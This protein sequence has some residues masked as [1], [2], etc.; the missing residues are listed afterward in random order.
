MRGTTKMGVVI[1]AIAI[2][3]AIN[4]LS[5][6]NVNSGWWDTNYKSCRDFVL[7]ESYGTER[8]MMPIIFNATGLV[9]KQANSDDFRLIDSACSE[10]GGNTVEYEILQNGTDWVYFAA[11]VNLAASTT[12]KYSFYWNYSDAVSADVHTLFHYANNGTNND[13]LVSLN[14]W[15]DIQ[16]DSLQVVA[17]TTNDGVA[18]NLSENGVDVI[19][20]GPLYFT[21]KVNATLNT[22]GQLFNGI[23]D[24]Y[25]GGGDF[26]T[27]NLYQLY[28]DLP[29]AQ[30][31]YSDGDAIQALDIYANLV[32]YTIQGNTSA[33]E[34][35]DN[36]I[37]TRAKI[38]EVEFADDIG[39]YGTATVGRYIKFVIGGSTGRALYRDIFL[40]NTSFNAYN[41]S[42]EMEQGE[43]VPYNPYLTEDNYIENMLETQNYDYNIRIEGD[44]E[45]ESVSGRF[46]WNGT[47]YQGTATQVDANN[48]TINYT[49]EMPIINTNSSNF[50]FFWEYNITTT[51]NSTLYLTQR[52]NATGIQAFLLNSGNLTLSDYVV[53]EGDSITSYGNITRL[54]NTSTVA[55]DMTFIDEGGNS[56]AGL[57]FDSA[58]NSY[59]KYKSFTVPMVEGSE[60]IVASTVNLTVNISH[61]GY[62]RLLTSSIGLN[63]S[64]ITL[65]ENSTDAL[66][67]ES[68]EFHIYDEQTKAIISNGNITTFEI[69]FKDVRVSGSDITREFSFSN[70]SYAKYIFNIFPNSSSFVI[71]ADISY[72]ATGY[73]TRNY[74]I[75]NMAIN[76]VSQI[77]KLYLG[78]IS[79]TEVTFT[80]QDSTLTPLEGVYLQ[81]Q[82]KDVGTGKYLNISRTP[83]DSNG[84]TIVGIQ[85]GSTHVYRFIVYGSDGTTILTEKSDTTLSFAQTTYTITIG[86]GDVFSEV[87]VERT[88]YW[89]NLSSTFT[90]NVTDHSQLVDNLVFRTDKRVRFDFEQVCYNSTTK[91][92]GE[93][94]NC[95]ITDTST[96]YRY[97]LYADVSG[98]R[99][100][101]ESG[102]IDFDIEIMP[103]FGTIGLIMVILLIMFAA[104][105]SVWSPAASIIST[106]VVIAGASILGII[107]ISEVALV[108]LIFVAG[109]IVVR[110][111][112]RE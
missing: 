90:C 48:W 78:N 9:D 105:M 68:L 46:N 82:K 49:M 4:V 54:I 2:V 92:D 94:Y 104:F 34:T 65:V 72:G 20:E 100:L 24:H 60:T 95:V 98:N 75:S 36:H 22:G 5:S 83:T 111:G 10:S 70:S 87:D 88:C 59:T 25:A 97:F 47:Y 69:W 26:T 107:G 32:W 96:D 102:W 53:V 73:D 42:I 86:A 27:N 11:F 99:Y 108:S 112:V 13:S 30:W 52:R 64:K 40:S 106:V 109:V 85:T 84:Q 28:G 77:I 67:M 16:N 58:N 74:Y 7:T 17:P 63:I 6:W 66:G 39:N 51:S 93:S 12:T 15:S 19:T 18:F 35:I 14:G 1:F 101:L 79:D 62:S 23:G 80:V 89:Q 43:I 45:T 55:I 103:A 91:T 21:Y 8:T 3:L 71:D 56:Y 57:L 31:R 110:M 81:I 37:G 38:D 61:K 29:N 41:Y 33:V 50:E 44:N 76:N